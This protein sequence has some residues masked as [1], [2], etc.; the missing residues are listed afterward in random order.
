MADMSSVGALVVG[1][2]EQ[3]CTYVYS[4]L[5]D[6]V[7]Q[8]ADVVTAFAGDDCFTKSGTQYTTELSVPLPAE[9]GYASATYTLNMADG[10]IEGEAECRIRDGSSDML[11]TVTFAGDAQKGEAAV[12]VHVK[13]DSITEITMSWSQQQ[14]PAGSEVQLPGAEQVITSDELETMLG[15]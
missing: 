7:Q 11:A 9:E 14:A 15:I 2:A 1:V 5:W 6:E 12:T 8:T 10:S 13:N 4:T 3:N